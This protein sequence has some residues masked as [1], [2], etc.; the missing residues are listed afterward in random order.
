[1]PANLENSAVA[2]GLEKLSFHSNPK[3]CYIYQGSFLLF[4]ILRCKHAKSLQTCPTLCDPVHCTPPGSSVHGI[5]QAIILEWVA[6]PS[7][8]GSSW[9]R[10]Q[11]CISCISCIAGGFFTTGAS[12]M[13][14]W[15]KNLPAM[16]ETWIQS[17]GWE[18]S[19]KKGKATHSSFL[20]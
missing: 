17:L 7:F 14:Q 16:R 2:T 5:L 9:P 8:R 15:V 10:D 11:T 20:A 4:W 12:L 1:M 3:E 13:A 18:D 19:L 6:V